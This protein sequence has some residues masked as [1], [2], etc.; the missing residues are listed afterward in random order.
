MSNPYGVDYDKPGF[1]CL[2]HV[3]IAEFD[4]FKPDMIP[5]VKRFLPIAC[6]EVVELDDGSKMTVKICT[7]CQANL[8]PADMQPLMESVQRGWQ[9]EV[10]NVSDDW[11]EEKKSAHMSKYRKR[12]ITGSKSRS[13]NEDEKAKIKKPRKA[14][15]ELR[16]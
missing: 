9:W 7:T 1:C 12:Y 2:C 6:D 15:Q 8:S 10:E 4:G 11:S 13:W 5:N 3:Q 16:K 14:S